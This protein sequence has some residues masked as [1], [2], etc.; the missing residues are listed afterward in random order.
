MSTHSFKSTILFVSVSCTRIAEN[1]DQYGDFLLVGLLC[2]NPSGEGELVYDDLFSVEVDGVSPLPSQP[3]FVKPF[4]VHKHNQNETYTTVWLKS[5]IYPTGGNGLPTK[6]EEWL[7]DS[8]IIVSM[9]PLSTGSQTEIYY[10]EKDSYEYIHPDLELG[11]G[12]K[13]IPWTKGKLLC[14]IDFLEDRRD[15]GQQKYD[16]NVY[17]STIESLT[18]ERGPASTV[19]NWNLACKN[20]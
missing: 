9:Y 2:A 3:Q 4:L 19:G 18:K 7:R 16:E 6:N 17:F 14:I 15:K 5:N 13:A 1:P 10:K 11:V 20:E 12:A 8:K